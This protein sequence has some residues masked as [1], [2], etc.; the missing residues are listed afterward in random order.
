M[1]FSNWTKLFIMRRISL[2]EL[3]R[4][5]VPSREVG[6]IPVSTMKFWEKIEGSA[7]ALWAGH[8]PIPIPPVKNLVTK[9]SG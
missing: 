7:E 2:H 5:R 6:L 9:P 4:M 3:T 8:S 1:M